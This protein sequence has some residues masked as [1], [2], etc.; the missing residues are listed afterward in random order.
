MMLANCVECKRAFPREGNAR[1]CPQCQAEQEVQVQ[2]V[3]DY[4]QVHNPSNVDE[5]HAGTKVSRDR[6]LEMFHSGRI[7]AAETMPDFFYPCQTCGGPIKFDRLCNRC[8]KK[9]FKDLGKPDRPSLNAH[10]VPPPP[11]ISTMPSYSRD[12]FRGDR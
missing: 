3:I 5:I 11:G 1:L 12:K 8:A 7:L 6:I 4:L 2:I 10:M 9:L